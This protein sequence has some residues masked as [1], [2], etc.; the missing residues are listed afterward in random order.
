VEREPVAS[1][2]IS[3]IGYDSSS[4]I[5]EIEYNSGAIYR[6][7]NVPASVYRELMEAPSKGA[8]LNRRLKEAGYSYS[9]LDQQER[10]SDSASN[11]DHRSLEQ[12]SDCGTSGEN[13]SRNQVPTACID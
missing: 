10:A 1:S 13:R 9:R 11:E 8:Y 2:V 3:S 12:G 6:Y 5:L 7:E 4:A